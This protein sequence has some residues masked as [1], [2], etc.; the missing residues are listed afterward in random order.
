[1]LPLRDESVEASV[2][3]Y[4]KRRYDEEQRTYKV[5]EYHISDF[6]GFGMNPIEWCPRAT[7]Y[8][9]LGLEE[10]NRERAGIFERGRALEVRMGQLSIEALGWEIIPPPEGQEQHT[11]EVQITPDIKL[12]AHIDFIVKKPDGRLYVVECKSI[13]F[14]SRDMFLRFCREEHGFPKPYTVLQANGY[15]WLKHIPYT[16]LYTNIGDYST[17][18]WTGEPEQALYKV[19]PDRMIEFDTNYIR[20]K[21]VPDGRTSWICS[22]DSKVKPCTYCPAFNWCRTMGKYAPHPAI[23]GHCPACNLDI[24]EFSFENNTSYLKV[25]PTSGRLICPKCSKRVI[26]RPL[27]AAKMSEF[28]GDEAAQEDSVKE[29]RPLIMRGKSRR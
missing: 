5:G 28:Y 29:F 14:H 2:D 21:V 9:Y 7:Y 18:A 19:V 10:Y 17:R 11:I 23:Y 27:T 20:P 3:A 13:N 24:P 22:F 4:I 25:E 12:I 15:G 6:I 8:R 16:I 26:K 1:M